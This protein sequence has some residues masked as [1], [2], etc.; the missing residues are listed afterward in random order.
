M[1]LLFWSREEYRLYPV[2]SL[3]QTP[4][5]GLRPLWKCG[6]VEVVQYAASTLDLVDVLVRLQFLYRILLPL[7]LAPTVAHAFS[8]AHSRVHSMAV[9]L[10]SS[11]FVG[12]EIR[13]L[14]P[15]LEIYSPLWLAFL[16]FDGRGKE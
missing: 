5:L 10:S 12:H 3:A 16:A 9:L 4:L 2:I 8:W 11:A 15:S 13:P 14:L 7:L 1:P 6:A